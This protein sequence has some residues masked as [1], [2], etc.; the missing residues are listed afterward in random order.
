LASN[1]VKVLPDDDK[2]R[3]KSSAT[4][5]KENIGHGAKLMNKLRSQ[6]ESAKAKNKTLDYVNET[7]QLT[8]SNYQKE[9]GGKDNA[10]N[11]RLSEVVAVQGSVSKLHIEDD[12][13]KNRVQQQLE[14]IEQLKSDVTDETLKL[15]NK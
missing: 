3:N 2:H 8:Q 5:S 4:K 11:P 6:V 14:Q 15:D 12:D 10:P 7:L 13:M 1:A 9:S